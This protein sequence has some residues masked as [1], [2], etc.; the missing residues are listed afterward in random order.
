MSREPRI[1]LFDI[2]TLPDLR[3]ALRCWPGISDFPGK[4][5]KAQLSSVLCIGWKVLG[6]D[7]VRCPAV[8]N[9]N[10]SPLKIPEVTTPKQFI[11]E[12]FRVIESYHDDS[13]LLDHITGILKDADAV[14]T[15]NGKRF[16]WK[17]LQTRLLKH[18]QMVLPKIIH[19]DTKQESSRNLFLFNNRLGNAGQ[20][21]LG[22]TKLDHE[23]WP[24]WVKCYH[25]DPKAMATMIKYCKQDVLLLEKY[26]TKLRPFITGL[27]NYTALS[28]EEN[29]CP[30]CGSK[31]LHSSGIR[32][33]RLRTYRRY[34]CHD[35]G[36]WS[37]GETIR[38]ERVQ[39]KTL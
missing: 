25:R 7:P 32:T 22:E 23:G 27:P 17:F 11:N 2:E 14:V 35:C 33:T 6:E 29:I 36:S 38:G 1:L 34:Y 18:N 24:L 16:D 20:F 10:G 19:I 4:T 26:F 37:Q 21:M 28:A 31:K 15:H 9:F 13:E 5:L 39:R 3:E 8:W 30:T 12:A